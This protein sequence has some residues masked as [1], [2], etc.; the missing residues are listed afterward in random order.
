[1]SWL[2]AFVELHQLDYASLG[3]GDLGKP[4]GYVERQ[5]LNWGKQYLKAATEDVPDATY[6]MRWLEENQPKEY[7]HSLIHNDFKYDN[8]VYAD[9]SFREVSA[10]LDWEMCTLGDP[11]MDLGSSLAYWSTPDDHP[12]LLQGLPSPTARPGNPGREEIAQRYAQRSGRSLDYL[13]FY[14]VYGLFK[15]AV[16]VQQLYYRYQKGLT[17]DQR[18]AYLNEA[19]KL[20]CLTGK[21]AVELNR[22]EKL[23]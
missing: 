3:L 18:F 13:V 16:V 19:T 8:V 14:Y 23:L 12:M 15:L 5:V 22:I 17:T 2:D 21:R 7:Q 11:L 10:I 1:T 9:R 6:I 4:A 20:F